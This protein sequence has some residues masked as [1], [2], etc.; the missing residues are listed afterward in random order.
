MTQHSH[1][2]P[3]FLEELEL[4]QDEVLD[5]LDDLERRV[6]S[7]LNEYVQTRSSSST[8]EG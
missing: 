5:Q 3:T 6:E 7:L 4:R 8:L 2:E 1:R